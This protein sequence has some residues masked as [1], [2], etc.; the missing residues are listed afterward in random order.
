VEVRQAEQPAEVGDEL[1]ELLL[2][3]CARRS[4]ACVSIW[5]GRARS[6]RLPQRELDAVLRRW[7]GEAV[8]QPLTSVP[9][10]FVWPVIT[11]VVELHAGEIVAVELAAEAPFQAARC[12]GSLSPSPPPAI[13]R[14][15]PCSTRSSRRA[16]PTGCRCRNRLCPG[17]ERSPPA[18]P[19]LWSRRRTLHCAR[20]P[21][22]SRPQRGDSPCCC[23]LREGSTCLLVAVNTLSERQMRCWQPPRRGKAPAEV[24]TIRRFSQ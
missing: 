11:Q 10:C 5:S 4:R 22:D 16:L 9:P 6:C 3:A 15:G 24:T 20:D 19:R 2:G 17:R 7:R 12:T 23:D 21:H 14:R 13:P 18:Y 8:E 1:L